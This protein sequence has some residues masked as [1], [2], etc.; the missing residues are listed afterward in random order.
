MT[1]LAKRRVPILVILL[2]ALAGIVVSVVIGRALA[3]DASTSLSA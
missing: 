3:A 1:A 2:M